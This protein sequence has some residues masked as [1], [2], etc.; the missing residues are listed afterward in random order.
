[1]I[2]DNAAMPFDCYVVRR[3]YGAGQQAGGETPAGGD[4]NVVDAEFEEVKDDKRKGS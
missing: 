3:M 4:D 2:R 1:M